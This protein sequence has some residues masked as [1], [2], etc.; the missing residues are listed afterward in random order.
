[1]TVQELY[2][3]ISGDYNEACSRLINEKLVAR[4][5]QKFPSDPSM[6]NLRSALAEGDFK[7]AFRAVHT[8]KGV[9]GNLAFTKLYQAAWNLTEQLRPQTGPADPVLLEQLEQEYV[10]TVSAIDE[11]AASQA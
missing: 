5:V 9:C 11:F 8:L 10:K 6:E 4:F 2:K 1:M 3:T 7:S